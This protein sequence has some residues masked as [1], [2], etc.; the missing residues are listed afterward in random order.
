MYST[1]VKLGN[2]VIKRTEYFVLLETFVVLMK[3][4]ILLGLAARYQSVQC[5]NI[6]DTIAEVSH[7][8][9]SL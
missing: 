6:P 3:G 2:N 8:P 9:I 7:K 4:Y 5:H 1:G